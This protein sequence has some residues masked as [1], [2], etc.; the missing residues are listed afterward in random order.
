MA[1]LRMLARGQVLKARQ[2]VMGKE[3]LRIGLNGRGLKV[4]LVCVCAYEYLMRG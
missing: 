2:L 3:W 1:T 4:F